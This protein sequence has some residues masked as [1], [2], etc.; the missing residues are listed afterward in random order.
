MYVLDFLPPAV[1]SG[2]R[3]VVVFTAGWGMKLTPLIG[4]I[5]A[6]LAITGITRYDISNFK[7]TRPGVLKRA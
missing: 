3:N 2:H 6:D 5:L 1:G 4:R 7:I